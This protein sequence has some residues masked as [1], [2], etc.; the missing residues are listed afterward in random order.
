MIPE[1]L[2]LSDYE[3]ETLNR[4]EP[5]LSKVA[6]EFAS[7]VYETVLNDQILSPLIRDLSVE[8]AK[9]RIKKYLEIFSAE[10]QQCKVVV[11]LTSDFKNFEISTS[12]IVE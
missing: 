5:L 12:K 10:D 8:D 3:R 4:Y 2:T 1:F 7:K 11:D 9:A 6:Y